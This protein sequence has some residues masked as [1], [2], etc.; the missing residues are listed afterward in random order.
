MKIN[1]LKFFKGIIDTDYMKTKTNTLK[2]KTNTP[3]DT[4]LNGGIE[5][6]TITNIYGPPGCGKSNISISTLLTILKSRKRAIYIDTENSFSYERYKQ[7][8]GTDEM[9]TNVIFIEPE[10]WEDQVKEI[11]KLDETIEKVK[12][13][14]IIIDSMV[15]LYR[16]KVHE[17]FTQANSELAIQYNN[18]SNISNT[19]KIPILVTNQIYNKQDT[20]EVEV[21]SKNISKYWSKALI[22]IK[23]DEEPGTRIAIIKKHRS[24]PEDT[25]IN[26]RITE[27]GLEN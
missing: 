5:T 20:D 11:E 13:S 25:M 17:N 6:D 26:F 19:M 12:P 23:R 14:I 15:S 16:I 24:L 3:L 27:N 18:L 7:M 10:K 8:G 2:I 9:L 22:E 1:K 4:I 21:S